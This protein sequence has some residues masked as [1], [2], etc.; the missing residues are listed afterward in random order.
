MFIS[1]SF[2]FLIMVCFKECS[3]TSAGGLLPVLG[4]NT[5]PSPSLPE[6]HEKICVSTKSWM[7]K[8]KACSISKS[9]TVEV[10]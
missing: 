4:K 3:A 10:W 1:F 6:V 9:S 2:S 8:L 7:F 5:G